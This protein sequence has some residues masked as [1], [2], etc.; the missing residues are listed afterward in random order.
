[1]RH[2]NRIILLSALAFMTAANV[3][4]QE[5]FKPFSH[6]SIG[7]SAG[8]DGILSFD[9]A[10]PLCEFIQARV[11]LSAQPGFS[12]TGKVKYRTHGGES[13]DKVEVKGKLH[14]TDFKMLFDFYPAANSSS[15]HFTA[16]AFIGSSRVVD[17][18]NTEPIPGILPEDYG[19]A[20]IE[21]GKYLIKT[22]K[23]GVAKADIKVN[24]FKPYLGIGFG[25]AV[26]K[27]KS[28]SVMCDIGV[29]FWGTPKVYSYDDGKAVRV[30]SKDVDNSDNGVLDIISKIAVYPV[31]NVRICGKIF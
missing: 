23:E 5:D 20:G 10:T 14:K 9:V 28:V 16:G 2:F 13:S 7:Y 22:D 26:P 30:T 12:Y 3:S 11:G 8:T 1:M 19:V 29:Q 31:L 6:L 4:A 21:I 15:F 24:S 17:I 18:H 25:R 27:T